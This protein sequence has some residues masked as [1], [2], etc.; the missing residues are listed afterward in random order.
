MIAVGPAPRLKIRKHGGGIACVTHC[1]NHPSRGVTQLVRER[2]VAVSR[3]S[4]V[5]GGRASHAGLDL[6]R[7]PRGQAEEEWQSTLL[8]GNL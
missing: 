6:R 3:G 2:F 4:R 8:F 7:R 5:T 1:V